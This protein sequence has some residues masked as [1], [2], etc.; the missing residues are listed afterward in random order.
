MSHILFTNFVSA[1]HIF[2][3]PGPSSSLV[4]WAQRI[5][6]CAYKF[7]S[8]ITFF[9]TKKY[10]KK[11]TRLV[12][13][14]SDEGHIFRYSFW[15]TIWEHLQI[16]NQRGRRNY[17]PSITVTFTHMNKMRDVGK[18]PVDTLKIRYYN[19]I[20]IILIYQL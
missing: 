17:T 16:V 18:I 9:I 5:K 7:T 11:K 1:L 13:F 15:K 12:N 3:Y 14:C 6:L 20:D 8:V 19:H 4:M 2:L 10:E